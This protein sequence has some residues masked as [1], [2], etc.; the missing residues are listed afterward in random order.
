M[1][2]NNQVAIIT[3]SSRGIGKA[4]AIAL[5]K[6]G[7]KV[8]INYRT[9]KARAEKVAHIIRENGGTCLIIQTDLRKRDQI[10]SMIE[11][12]MAKWGRIDILVNNA[13]IS[14]RKPLDEFT[15]EEYLDTIDVNQHGTVN[16]CWWGNSFKRVP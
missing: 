13:G 9:G 12:T 3:G 15:Y 2:F 6:Y 8:V 11:E 4:V 16:T 5:A 1:D 14:N 7:A 10:K